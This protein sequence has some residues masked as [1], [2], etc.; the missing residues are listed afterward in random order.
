M[1]AEHRHNEPCE[2]LRALPVQV[3]EADGAVILVR[4]VAEIQIGG[5]RAVEMVSQ[6]LEA[7]SGEGTT[8]EE[9]IGQFAVPDRE[10]I[11]KLVDELTKRSILVGASDKPFPSGVESSLDV[12]YW[13]FKQ[14]VET[15]I[16]N[17]NE[18][19]FVLM[20][21][22]T[23]SR[24]IATA[25]DS[26]GAGS[27]QVVDFHILR[28]LRLYDDAGNLLPDEWAG[29][30]PITY[31]AWVDGLD[32]D[33]TSCLVAS[34]DFG[35]AHLLRQWNEFCVE[36]RVHFLPVILDRFIGSIGPLVIPG[37]TPCYECLR[38]R[39]NSNMDAPG[40][41]R[42]AESSAADRQAVTG[43]HPAM[44]SVLAELAAME[45]CKVYGGGLPWRSGRLIEVNLLGPEIFS[46]RV[47]KLPR[48][49][50]CSPT[51]KSSAVYVDKQSF[52]PGH[53]VNFHEF[54]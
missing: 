24:R 25:L 10:E 21:V 53:Q 6:L 46:R 16:S 31:D 7:A 3:I 19:S 18:K 12:F 23:I 29:P 8:R 1:N 42:A 30:A 33:E 11:G 45:L 50:V 27:V 20:G 47:L 49:P 17:L 22:N 28:N 39:E 43:F 35:G 44:T 4:G 5:Q 40:L 14:T 51:L 26:L 52:V 15:T 32:D 2:R 37:E 41:E 13:H 48:C 34:S 38:L 54:R 9:I 36:N